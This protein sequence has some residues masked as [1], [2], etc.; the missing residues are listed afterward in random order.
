MSRPANQNQQHS[1][2]S[3]CAVFRSMRERDR[4]ARENPGVR[5]APVFESLCGARFDEVRVMFNP[6][7]EQERDALATA[8]QTRV[9]PGGKWVPFDQI[10]G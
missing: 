2:I 3:V 5:A 1:Q 10:G 7:T 6:E 8:W 9:R 4:W